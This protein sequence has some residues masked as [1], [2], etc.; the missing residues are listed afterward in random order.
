[1]SGTAPSWDQGAPSDYARRE[2][3]HWPGWRGL[4]G[5]DVFL[6]NLAP[7]LFVV[8]VLGWWLAP[9]AMGGTV[10]PLL[11]LAWLVLLAD[12]ALLVADLGDAWRFVHMMR[13]IKPKSPMSVGV[14]AL[15]TFAGLLTLVVLGA[16]LPGD[17]ALAFA[18]VL[19]L[20]AAMPALVVLCYKGVL[21]SCTSQ[22]G[23]RDARW[24]SAH[25]AASGLMLGVATA[26]L[27][28]AIMNAPAQGVA[29]SVL[30]TLIVLAAMTLFPLWR[31]V[32]ARAGVRYSAL[33]QHGL[34][35]IVVLGGLVAPLV[36]V[37]A[38]PGRHTFM[39]AALLVLLGGL[40]LRHAVVRLAEPVTRA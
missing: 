33:Q 3:V 31:D 22:P 21:F 5:W 30:A 17:H 18:K 15:S 34:L 40:V 26:L 13:V 12:L 20:V 14:W 6:N 19:A 25:L 2:I 24:L 37:L 38:T 1:M 28:A 29:R 39:A 32:A 4:I 35:W 11:T 36:L 9:V 23:L 16:W 8:T 7:G 10:K 27:V